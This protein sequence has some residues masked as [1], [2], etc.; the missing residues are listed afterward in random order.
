MESVS[1][2]LQVIGYEFR[3]TF[4]TSDRLYF[5]T[6]LPDPKEGMRRYHIHLTY[7]ENREWKE[8][9]IFRDYL[10]NS[11]KEKHEYAQLKKMA[12]NEAEEDGAKYRKLKEP[13]F[14]K[15][16]F[17]ENSLKINIKG[18]KTSE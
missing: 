11:R 9:L 13:F 18:E 17:L 15:I 4:S 14:K 8:F 1:Q 7:P 16:H 6:Y 3:A 10:R 12:A 2:Q 5:T